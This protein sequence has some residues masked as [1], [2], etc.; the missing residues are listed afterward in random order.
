MATE[1]RIAA[2][3]WNLE[4]LLK[5]DSDLFFK[6]WLVQQKQFK[7]KQEIRQLTKQISKEIKEAR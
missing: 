7:L 2:L 4:K 3:V 5:R 1:I 6:A